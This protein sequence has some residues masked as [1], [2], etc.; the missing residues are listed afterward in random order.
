MQLPPVD[1]FRI[2]ETT[3]YTREKGFWLLDKHVARLKRSA[4]LLRLHYP[5]ECFPTEQVTAD[6]VVQAA[7]AVM[8]AGDDERYRVCTATCFTPESE[9]QQPDSAQTPPVLVLDSEPT[10]DTDSV[11][12]K[13]KTT[14][15]QIY[16]RAQD[17]IPKS[18]PAG[19]QVLLFNQDGLVTEGNIANVAVGVPV[20]GEL[21][22]VTPCVDAGLLAGTAR[23][24]FI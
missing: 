23:S 22:L 1:S 3:L 17:R 5:A 21:R 8:A 12:V 20:N 24:Q 14:H 16:E 7:T 19:T 9:P 18:Y 2:L 4:D 13:C 15:R 11:F 10:L 6:A